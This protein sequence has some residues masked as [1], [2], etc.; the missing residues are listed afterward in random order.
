MPTNIGTAQR[1]SHR[2]RAEDSNRA[3][4]GIATLWL[5]FY[6]VALGVAI[7][8]PLISR[9]IEFTALTRDY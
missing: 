6:A 7:S 9:T 2:Q 8:S 5:V 4:S 1:S 3:E